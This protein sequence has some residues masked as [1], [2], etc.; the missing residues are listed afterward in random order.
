M[1]EVTITP[2]SGLSAMRHALSSMRKNQRL[3]WEIGIRMFL[4]D[5]RA[6]YRQSLLSYLWIF[7]PPLATTLIW[8]Y[9]NDQKVVNVA[10]GD[11]NYPI[12]VLSGNL[13]WGVFSGSLIGMLATLNDARSMLSKVNFP[14]EALLLSAL[15]KAAVNS[16]LP[17]LLLIPMLPFYVNSFERSMLLLPVGALGLIL[18]GTTIAIF[19]LP[20]AT[21]YQDVNRGAQLILR[22]TFFLTPIVYPLPESGIAKI[23]AEWNPVTPILVTT[24]SWLLGSGPEMHTVFWSMIIALP[25]LLTV[26]IIIFKVAIPYLVER[27]SA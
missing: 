22:F 7:L 9:L 4:R 27:L 20:L 10:H 2:E 26:G 18:L 21:L 13:L 8:V 6:M 24:R 23:I 3:A 11:K 19:L 1:Q 16:L 17:M 5:I 25:I 15:G 14:H 12:F